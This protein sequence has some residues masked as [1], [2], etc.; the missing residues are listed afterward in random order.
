MPPREVR[1][2]L[3]TVVVHTKPLVRRREVL[4]LQERTKA[5][6]MADRGYQAKAKEE[7]AIWQEKVAILEEV[8]RP[9]EDRG[10]S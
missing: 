8:A 3:P 10:A 2:N 4:P 9:E 5:L 6:G 7:T 1:L